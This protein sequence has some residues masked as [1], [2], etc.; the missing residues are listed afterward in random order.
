LRGRLEASGHD[1]DVV[2][3]VESQQPGQTGIA[4]V[5][6]NGRALVTAEPQLSEVSTW[7]AAAGGGLIILCL[8][9]DRLAE[10]LDH[11]YQLRLKELQRMRRAIAHAEAVT[12][13]ADANSKTSPA[14]TLELEEVAAPVDVQ[15]LGAS[16]DTGEA[17][18]VTDDE[19]AADV[20]EQPERLQLVLGGGPISDLESRQLE[21]E[22]FRTELTSLKASY[23]SARADALVAGHP[24]DSDDVEL[25]AVA[26]NLLE[27][28]AASK[29]EGHVWIVTA[30]SAW[31]SPA[32]E[33]G[34]AAE[35]GRERVSAEAY[36]QRVNESHH[37]RQP[38]YGRG[39]MSTVTNRGPGSVPETSKV[40]VV[41]LSNDD[42]DPE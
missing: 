18:I 5:A 37:R 33:A 30:D 27:A 40:D 28:L 24:W 32:P 8:G 6:A 29:P 23:L 41:H 14:G 9:T 12:E 10:P 38:E 2:L 7:D 11:L 22:S 13:H 31:E 42:D 34:E 20:A 1:V 21:A 19:A 36:R 25:D 3:D 17:P 26:T 15:G 4:G 35:V 39:T 16:A